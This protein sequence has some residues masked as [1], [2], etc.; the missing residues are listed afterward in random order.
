MDSAYELGHHFGTDDVVHVGGYYDKW[1]VKDT[2]GR[3]WVFMSDGSIETEVRQDDGT[4]RRR[5]SPH[6]SVELVTPTLGYGE[7]GM[8]RG[9]VE[10]L[11]SFGLKTNESCGVHVHVSCDVDDSPESLGTLLRLAVGR[12]DMIYESLGVTREREMAWC[13][14]TRESVAEAIAEAEDMDGVWDAWY[15]YE[16]AEGH[17]RWSDREEHYNGT[18]YHGINLHSLYGGKGVE[19]RYFNGTMDAD[20]IVAYGQLCA[21]MLSFSLNN[22]GSPCKFH[23]ADNYTQERKRQL[24]EGFLKKRLGLSGVEFQT[25]RRILLENFA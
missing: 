23:D 9:V 19:F 17:T 16:N 3:K 20:R 1:S 11:R 13:H 6:H 25:T 15:T 24:F 12:E 10:H 2:R 4:Y 7:L 5:F 18:R 8:L 14:K 21:G 22:P